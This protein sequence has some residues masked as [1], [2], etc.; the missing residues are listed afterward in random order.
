MRYLPPPSP[1]QEPMQ[2]MRLRMRDVAHHALPKQSLQDTIGHRLEGD[3][4][5]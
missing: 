2:T 1:P 4:G 3:R 5:S